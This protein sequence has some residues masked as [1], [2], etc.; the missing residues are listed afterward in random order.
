MCVVITS[1]Q[2]KEKNFGIPQPGFVAATIF[3]FKACKALSAKKSM[4]FF[5]T[6]VFIPEGMIQAS[7]V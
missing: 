2:L 1:R 7:F 4:A 5:R 3:R 6:I